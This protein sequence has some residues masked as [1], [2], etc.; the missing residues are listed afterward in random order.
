MHGLV[1]GASPS[2]A[3]KLQ[4]LYSSSGLIQAIVAQSYTQAQW[5]TLWKSLLG[6]GAQST[7]APTIT[8]LPGP[9]TAVLLSGAKNSA[10][11]VKVTV[12]GAINAGT[13]IAKI[14]FGT[15]GVAPAYTNIPAVVV[16]SGAF[17]IDNTSNLEFTVTNRVGLANGDTPIAAI[18]VGSCDAD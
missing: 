9:Y 10:M 1:L 14:K 3:Q 8:S 13:P 2:Q 7:P 12:T 5:A 6:G 18:L 4:T 11:N 17:Q 15:A 16:G